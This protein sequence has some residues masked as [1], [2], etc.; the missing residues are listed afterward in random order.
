M[1]YTNSSNLV[2]I[3][4]FITTLIVFFLDQ[5]F[6]TSST[7]IPHKSQYP[8]DILRVLS[9]FEGCNFLILLRKRDNNSTH[10]FLSFLQSRQI[11]RIL[12]N[13]EEVGPLQKPNLKPSSPTKHSKCH[14]IFIDLSWIEHYSSIRS[15]MEHWRV[16][17]S[18]I[19]TM[20]AIVLQKLNPSYIFIQYVQYGETNP[21]TSKIAQILPHLTVTS[22]FLAILVSSRKP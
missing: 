13:N 3:N 10:E 21:L 16:E 18:L 4:V 11:P 5:L 17:I 15:S 7:I 6:L 19:R 12:D 1:R 14:S 8:A 20:N 9:L 2:K 22:E